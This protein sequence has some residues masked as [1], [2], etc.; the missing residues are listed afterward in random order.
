MLGTAIAGIPT[1]PAA[2]A[3]AAAPAALLADGSAYEA[4]AAP[5]LP[6][7]RPPAPPATADNKGEARPTPLAAETVANDDAPWCAIM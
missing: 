5:P 2:V 3:V 7:S 1:P 4:A 6:A